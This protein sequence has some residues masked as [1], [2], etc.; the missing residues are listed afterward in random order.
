MGPVGDHRECRRRRRQYR[1]RRS[2]RADPDGYTLLLARRAPSRTNAFLTRTCPTIRRSGS[3]S[4]W[5]RLRLTSGTKPG[6]SGHERA[7][8]VA[9]ARADPGRLISA[10]P[11]VGSVGQFATIESKCSQIST[12]CRFPTRVRAG[13]DRRRRR[14]CQHDVRHAGDVAADA[15]G[16]SERIV[17]VGGP[18]RVRRC[19]SAA[20]AEAG[21]PGFRAVTFF[22][23]VAP[24]RTPDA[25]ADKINRDIV[26]SLREPNPWR[27]SELWAWT[28]RRAAAKKRRDSSRSERA[29]WG[30][31]IKRANIPMQ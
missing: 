4:P 30:K 15:P 16:R 8:V 9:R 23:I 12:C 27:R 3:R 20:L 2:L 22:G 18:E 26:E 14:Q 25:L 13:G 17:A 21:V 6:F 31:V 7:D 29:L 5:W 1:R 19:P 24:P 10:T 28:W 11:G